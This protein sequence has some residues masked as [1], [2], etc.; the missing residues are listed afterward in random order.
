MRVEA[1]EK[2]QKKA[3]SEAASSKHE[4]RVLQDQVEVLGA[5]TPFQYTAHHIWR[6]C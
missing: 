5:F 3:S 4:V 2:E 6:M 1:Q